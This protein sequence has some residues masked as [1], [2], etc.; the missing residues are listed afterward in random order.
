VR[1]I[2]KIGS[3][4]IYS[5]RHDTW[6]CNASCDAEQDIAFE[7]RERNIM[8]VIGRYAFAAAALLTVVGP[9]TA[10][11]TTQ[12]CV[13]GPWMVFFDRDS[14]KIR[15]ESAAILDNAAD[16][17][18]NCGQ[19][20]VN[21]SGHTDRKGTDQ[22]NVG[23]SQR[24]AMSVRE[25]LAARGIPDGVITTEAFGESRPLVETQDGVSE[26]QNR[27]VEIYFGPGSGW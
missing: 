16:A 27:R 1:A 14:D 13:A 11:T 4:A 26:P 5:F 19:F 24:M 21:V 3:A 8:F 22:Y 6:Y 2:V 12:P 18:K 15:I 10:Q 25:Y 20:V 7:N 23:L 9:A 17:Y